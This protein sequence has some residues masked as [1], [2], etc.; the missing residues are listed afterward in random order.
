[1]LLAIMLFF[2]TANIFIQNGG[3][4]FT[5]DDFSKAGCQAYQPVLT[6]GRMW[7]LSYSYRDS[8]EDIPDAYM[9]VTVDGDSIVD[10]KTYK[11]YKMFG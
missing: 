5:Q 2:S 1:M 7:K 11:I 3:N 6:E 9:A 8:R 10:G 4:V